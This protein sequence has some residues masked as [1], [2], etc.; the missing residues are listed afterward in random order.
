MHNFDEYANKYEFLHM[1]R[2]NGILEVALHTNGGPFI[3]NAVAHRELSF[4]FTDI[5]TDRENKVI[6]LTGTGD[7]F[8]SGFDIKSFESFNG[9]STPRGWDQSY[10]NGKRMLSCLLEIPVPVIGA[11]NGPVTVHSQLAVLNDIVLASETAVFQDSS[12][13]GNGVVPGDGE[14]VI[15]PLLLGLN[16]G[17]YFLLTEQ[18]L[19]AQEALDLGV[20]SEVLPPDQLLPRAWE[21]AEQLAKQPPLA[22][23]YARVVLTQRLKRLMDEG[24]GYGLALEGLSA[25]DM[26]QQQG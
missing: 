23:R 16:R 8:C 25:N 24:L 13:F 26:A 12:H 19:S 18:K 22:L 1:E 21:L 14:H 15:W 5:G 7:S 9:I 4:A 20:V 10:F 11:V 2:R 3:F 17:R 6:I